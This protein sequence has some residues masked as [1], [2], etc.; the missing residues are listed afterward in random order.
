[1]SFLTPLKQFI[2]NVVLPPGKVLSTSSQTAYCFLIG[3]KS[4]PRIIV[5]TLV[6]ACIGFVLQLIAGIVCLRALWILR[7][8]SKSR[9][10]DYL[11]F[12]TLALA[13]VNTIGLVT[14]V[15]AFWWLFGP[16]EIWNTD[17]WAKRCTPAEHFDDASS[18]IEQ[19]FAR[20]KTISLT[21]NVAFGISG[22][23][24]DA[25]LIW[26]C[27]QIWTFTSFPRPDFIIFIPIILLVGSMVVFAWSCVAALFQGI[28][29]E[30][31]FANTL[32]LNII[33]TSL[34]VLRLWQ[35]KV[36]LREVLGVEHG[37][38]YNILSLV[39][40]ES[41]FMNAV[42]SI[43]LLASLLSVSKSPTVGLMFAVW[44]A[45]TPAIQACSSYLIIYRGTK[46]WY[47]SWSNNATVTN[48]ST[49]AF[50]T[51]PPSSS[52]AFER[53]EDGLGED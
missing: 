45:I 9:L 5:A 13:I 41:A 37:Q 26:R 50:G 52:R 51:P 22:L 1:M 33:L 18:E 10:V 44:I 46:G 36:Q 28:L 47:G 42:C 48:P 34:I 15:L 2:S 24:T 20:L 17:R 32:A 14:A 6:S 8:K 35:C 16:M 12:H 43:L 23:L 25:M 27:R 40:V 21:S 29:A 38:H 4:L 30:I 39:F 3:T 31:Y 19:L 7:R 53:S 49:V 11:M